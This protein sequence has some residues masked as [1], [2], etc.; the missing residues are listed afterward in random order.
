MARMNGYKFGTA[1]LCVL[2]TVGATLG[3]EHVINHKEEKED[4]ENTAAVK[5]VDFSVETGIP[6]LGI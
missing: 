2:L 4:E 5:V 3:I 6:E 1:V